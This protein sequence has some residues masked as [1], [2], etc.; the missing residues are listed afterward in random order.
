MRDNIFSPSFGN[1]P[2][3][4]IGRDQLIED[5][6]EGLKT[7]Q[8][9]RERATLILGQ[10]GSGKTV[11]LWEIADLAKEIDYV[12]ATPTIASE[13]MLERIVEKIQDS[14]EK[15][16]GQDA[17]RISGGNIGALGFSFGLQFTKTVQETKSAQYKLIQLARKLT[18]YKKGLLFLVDE[19]QA[20]SSDIKQ[21]VIAYQEMVGEGLNVA[22]VMAGLPGAVSATLNDK[23][24][25]FLN[26]ARKI[27]L[28]PLA[29]SDVDAYFA[30]SFKE[31]G[32]DIPPD[33]RNIAS[34]AVNG[35]PYLL[36]LIGH[37][38]VAYS[39]A[40]A[41]IDESALNNAI[42][43]AIKDFEN[44]ICKTSLSSLSDIDILFLRSL[45]K[46]GSPAKIGEIAKGMNKTNDYVQKYRARLLEAGIIEAPMRGKVSIA[47]PYLETYLSDDLDKHL[48]V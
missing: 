44:D 15:H 45:A 28:N 26:R 6:T 48:S 22:L 14:G 30:R 2:K 27:E 16:I 32:L 42:N 37:N 25:T 36:Q 23:V 43:A 19:L 18:E 17:H 33:L 41:T 9:S 20:N 39:D 29:F 24:L 34:Y 3:R 1:R 47:I 40:S 4:I 46:L 21:L 38:I 35:S 13:G 31:L 5:L 12:V 8:G 11:L 10:R 7:T